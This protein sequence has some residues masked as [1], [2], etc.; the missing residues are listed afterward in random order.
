MWQNFHILFTIFVCISFIGIV[1]WIFR[2]GSKKL[3]DS[4]KRIPTNDGNDEK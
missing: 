1:L 3:Y 2:P 4:Y